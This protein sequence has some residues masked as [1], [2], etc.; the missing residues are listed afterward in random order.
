MQ[1]IQLFIPEPCHENWQ[2]M[3][4]TQ[5][6]RF[7]NAC[8]KQVIDFS[9]MSDTEV[10]NYFSTVKN[11]KVCGRAYPGQLERTIT[12]PDYP[13]KK[14]F[15]YWNYITMLFLFFSKSNN[16]KAQGGVKI[17]TQSQPNNIKSIPVNNA[18]QGKVGG[19]VVHNNN[20]VKGK[21]IDETGEPISGASITIKGTKLG[22]I[23]DENGYYKI[24][25]NAK[26]HVLEINA[27][28]FEKKE[29]M[30]NAL[31]P[32]EIVLTKIERQLMGDVV[33]VGGMISTAESYLP[34]EN[35]KHV[36]VFEVIDNA[37]MQPVNKA[38]VIIKKNGAYHSDLAHTDKKGIYKLKK[39]SDDDVFTVKII[40]EGFKE[41]ELKIK[42]SDFKERKI[43]KQ[44]FLEKIPSL[45]D[46]KKL[47]S[48]FITS[49]PVVGKLIRCTT[50]TERVTMG[51]MISGV[52]ITRTFADSIKLITSKI[53]GF[54]KIFPNPVQKGN[55]FNLSLK[56]KQ[57]G[58]YNIQIIDVAGKIVLQKQIIATEKELTE[59][60]PTNNSWSSGIYYV[61]VFNSKNKF[62]STGSFRLQ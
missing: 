32:A 51:A 12:F 25:T 21:I 56:L 38:A 18:L 5:Q 46:Y 59:H 8:A 48:V 40:A 60:I 31:N 50:T 41:E 53:T 47:D 58:I 55:S 4:A 2:Q 13:K 10:L 20:L 29:V 26:N 34:T 36:V 17:T 35:P 11:E 54:I 30:L 7:C 33:I 37:T 28:G 23:S 16:V 24:N 22:M 27:V 15:W 14:M 45:A 39:I 62:I 52:I 43:A 3:T 49:Y 57:T 42:G 61:R 9:I 1:Q 44:I 6:G 19:V